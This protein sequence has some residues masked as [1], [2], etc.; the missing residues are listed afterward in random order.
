[1]GDR[2]NA[3]EWLVDRHVGAG[4]GDRVAFRCR[5]ESLSY[6][7]LLA[8]I[9]RAQHALGAL[10]VGEGDRV[11]MVVR[12]ELAFPAWFLGAMRS[13]AVPVPLS[14]MLHSADLGAI[15]ADAGAKALVVSGPDVAH[16]GPIVGTAST[17]A[18]VVVIDEDVEPI[19]GVDTHTWSAFTDS[20]EAPIAGTARDSNGFWLY[21]SG[22]TGLPKGVMHR[23]G[24]PEHTAKTYASSVIDMGAD[25]RT[26][27]VAKLFFA[28]GLGNSLTFPLAFGATAILNPDPPTP[29]GVLDLLRDEQPT[30][31][32]AAPGFVAALLDA[33]APAEAFASVRATVTAGE[34][35]PAD[36]QRR[37]AERTGRPVLDGIGTTEALHIFMSNRP[38]HERPGTS[39]TPV[40]G[41]D[42]ELLDEHGAEVVEPD[43]PGYLHVRGASVAT[44]Y[45]QRPEATA[46]A[47]SHGWLRTGDVYTRSADGYYT[48]LGRNNDMIKAGGIWVSPAEVES[49]LIEHP[50][51]LEAAVVGDRDADGLETV[52]AFVVPRSGRTIDAASIEAHC[53]ERMAAFKRPRRIVATDV[54]PKT[55]TGKVQRYQLRHQL[56][57]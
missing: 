28:Y 44:G 46:E 13:G 29:A 12:D 21:S 2:Y 57:H 4:G 39:G 1:M 45:W 35:L 19:T 51:V 6:E 48:F 10:G 49:V 33:G 3:A 53:R 26:L 47:F 37:F 31:F 16:A 38:G 23:H 54:L 8:E 9:W 20:S 52:V 55:A 40:E 5:G 36:L 14:T 24:N 22:T 43:T 30:M 7:A 17:I 25:D 27:S 42:V 34:S 50:D 56:T 41:Y 15:A 32:F 11:V 18:H